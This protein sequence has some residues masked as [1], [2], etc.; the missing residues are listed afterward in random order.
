MSSNPA[1]LISCLLTSFA[2][3]LGLTRLAIIVS[4]VFKVLW[5]FQL[6]QSCTGIRVLLQKSIASHARGSLTGPLYLTPDT[7]PSS[8]PTY[9][10]KRLQT[11][12]RHLE[13]ECWSQPE[14]RTLEPVLSS[15]AA[16]CIQISKMVSRAQTDDIYGLAVDKSTGEEL[17]ANV[18][19]EAQQKLD[20]VCNEIMLRAFCGPSS[21][22]AAVASE[23]E[24]S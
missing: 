22:V 20:V 7:E 24:V 9:K 2:E 17:A 12:A 6:H 11:F 4:V 21:N 13:I 19:G 23:E 14:L 16:A 1:K 3:M 15:V 8:G 5:A 10:K 18:Q